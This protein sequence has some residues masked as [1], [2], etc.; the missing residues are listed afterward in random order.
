MRSHRW[1]ELRRGTMSWGWQRTTGK[2]R[3]IKRAAIAAKER[4]V[5]RYRLGTRVLVGYRLLI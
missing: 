2:G 1:L 3:K 4:E 5:G